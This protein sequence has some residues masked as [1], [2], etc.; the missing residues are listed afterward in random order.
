LAAAVATRN[1]CRERG[2]EW[3]KKEERVKEKRESERIRE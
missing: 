1:L 3:G 2:G